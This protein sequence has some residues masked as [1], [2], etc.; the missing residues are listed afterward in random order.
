M[1]IAR[2]W[3]SGVVVLMDLFAIAVGNSGGPDS[4]CLL[5]L[6]HRYLN[7]K[8]ATNLQPR[9]LVSLSIDHNLQAS[10]SSMAAQAASIADSLGI[11][12][13]TAK[14]PWG[15][16]HHPQKPGPGDKIEEK[17]RDMRQF[18]LFEHLKKLDANALAFGHHADDQVETMLMRLGRGSSGIGLA[19]MRPCRRWGMGSR[20]EGPN[21]YEI[22]GMRRWIVRPLL[23]VPKVDISLA[24]YCLTNFTR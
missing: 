7:G 3:I 19:G 2:Y 24:L 16:G 6:L 23:G 20:T 18:V 4:I 21:P 5:F 14:L 9:S 11:D 1:V 17:A 22:E 10:S 8:R 12:H 13:V 15:E